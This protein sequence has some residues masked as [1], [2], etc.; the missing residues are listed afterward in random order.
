M[1]S[2]YQQ[3]LV[4]FA[5]DSRMQILK[6]QLLASPHF[7]IMFAVFVK[8]I[9][10]LYLINLKER[11]KNHHNLKKKFFIKKKIN[12]SYLFALL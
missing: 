4:H 1:I 5:H 12:I 2:P 10:Y 9:Y 3:S 11:M 8:T 6:F 7:N